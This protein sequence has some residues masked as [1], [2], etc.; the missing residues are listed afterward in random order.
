MLLQKKHRLIHA[1]VYWQTVHFLNKKQQN[2]ILAEHN[3]ITAQPQ[4]ATA[5][6]QV[7][8]AQ[9]PLKEDSYKEALQYQSIQRKLSIGAV[10]DPLEN[11]ADAMADKVMRMPEQPFVQRKCADCEEEE[12][13]QR[14]P[15]AASIT[16]FIQTKG[17]DGGTASDTVTEQINATRGSGSNMDRPTQSFMESRFGT[18]FSN[19][20][21]HTGDNAIQMSQ[22][23]NAQAFTVGSDIYFNNG[24]YNPSSE[25]GKHL[26]AHELTHTVQQGGDQINKYPGGHAIQRVIDERPYS[27][28]RG[29]GDTIGLRWYIEPE[30]FSP[31][32]LQ[33]E[34]V[35]F[36]IKSSR[37]DDAEAHDVGHLTW[38]LDGIE[39]PPEFG[40][41][42]ENENIL[43]QRPSDVNNHP[44]YASQQFR[45]LGHRKIFFRGNPCQTIMGCGSEIFV[46]YDIDV[47]PSVAAPEL[48]ATAAS[49]SADVDELGDEHNS[50]DELGVIIRRLAIRRAFE[51]LSTNKQEVLDMQQFYRTP[52]SNARL[53]YIQDIYRVYEGLSNDIAE[54][55]PLEHERVEIGLSESRSR[56]ARE[57][58]RQLQYAQAGIIGAYPEVGAYERNRGFFDNP[59]TADEEG[60]RGFV[61]EKLGEVA[62][63]IDDTR[64]NIATNDMNILEVRSMIDRVAEE[65][66]TGNPRVAQSITR[67]YDDRSYSELLTNLLFGSGQIA[68]LFVPG[69]GPYLSFAL[70]LVQAGISW[71]HAIDMSTAANTGL[72]HGIVSD[73]EAA[74]AQFWAVVDAVFAAIDGIEAARGTLRTITSLRRSTGIAAEEV[75]GE[76]TEAAAR[77]GASSA[78]EI[79]GDSYEVARGVEMRGHIDTP[80]GMHHLESYLDG[81]C[82]ICS[83]T[84]HGE[85]CPLLQT[86]YSA[87]LTRRTVISGELQQLSERFAALTAAD[88]PT[89]MLLE[90]TEVEA[91]LRNLERID[92]ISAAPAS[93][94]IREVAFDNAGITVPL[95][96]ENAVLEYPNGARAWRDAEGRVL[97]EAIVTPNIGRQGSE[98]QFYSGREMRLPGYERLERSHSWPQ[99]WGWES[100]HAIPYAP[101]Y[102]NQTLQNHGIE[103]YVERLRDM[104][105]PGRELM[106][107]T[108]TVN[109]SGGRTLSSIEYSIDVLEGTERYSIATYRIDMSGPIT[110]PVTDAQPIQFLTGTGAYH[111]SVISDTEQLIPAGARPPIIDTIAHHI[112]L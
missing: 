54:L 36:N 103:V 94:N 16:P 29:T 86:T 51:T 9:E 83:P 111:Q 95:Y 67:M 110:L 45:S 97:Q 76:S 79:I 12:M 40:V 24:K 2:N 105:P 84:A 74:A 92:S 100:P 32:I 1:I 42:D 99:R 19:V 14:S 81:T 98:R 20:K 89:E 39:Q 107:R 3:I 66:G 52:E 60:F 4:T 73:E 30:N 15:L 59:T 37:L 35:R 69:I 27:R 28:Q 47:R 62:T 25:S 5:A 82:G 112:G 104:M 56:Q 64:Y 50:L 13:I 88:A 46:V 90:L 87:V 34:T 18:D 17:A 49:V 8:P 41:M 21:I 38:M 23:L 108:R 68:L 26:L 58:I 53:H 33:N 63:A 78:P 44:G 72:A 11:E 106:V 65:Y 61:L 71:E 85:H 80:D 70:G 91:R 75:A 55:R 10:D 6:N 57:H 96:R 101:P 22:E 109:A 77:A 93:W 102:V 7:M 31:I 48:R 43:V